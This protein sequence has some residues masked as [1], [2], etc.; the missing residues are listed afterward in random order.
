MFFE[1][2]TDH[3]TKSFLKNAVMA[4]TLKM[5]KS[6]FFDWLLFA[7]MREVSVFVLL[8]FLNREN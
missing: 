7:A 1:V 8:S 2:K 4:L 3:Q 5:K 6:W